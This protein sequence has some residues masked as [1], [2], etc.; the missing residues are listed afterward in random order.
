MLWLKLHNY[1]IYRK[2]FNVKPT[3][4]FS[5]FHLISC[6]NNQNEKTQPEGI[7]LGFDIVQV[8]AQRFARYVAR[9]RSYA[10]LSFAL[11]VEFLDMT[12][13]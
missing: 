10:A 2:N 12:I 7:E 1:Y 13:E 11:V 3:T 8:L 9:S 4:I 5:I 6:T